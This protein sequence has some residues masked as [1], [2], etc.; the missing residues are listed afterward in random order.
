MHP[1]KEGGVHI[2]TVALRVHS[3]TEAEALRRIRSHF[4]EQQWPKDS[5]Q[6]LAVEKVR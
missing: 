1:A 5:I 2:V 3:D 6:Y 4:P